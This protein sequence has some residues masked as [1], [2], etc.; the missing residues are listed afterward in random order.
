MDVSINHLAWSAQR[1]LGAEVVLSD[2]DEDTLVETLA[3]LI[4]THRATFGGELSQPG[5][6]PT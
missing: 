4:W 5:R 1:D 6:D 3:N 2:A